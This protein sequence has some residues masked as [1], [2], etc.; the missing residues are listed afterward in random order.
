VNHLDKRRNVF[1]FIALQVP[2]MMP[3]DV[4]GQCFVFGGQ[5]LDPVF[6][7]YWK[8]SWGKVKYQSGYF[9]R[10]EES[11]C[12]NIVIK[13]DGPGDSSPDTEQHRQFQNLSA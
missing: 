5:F 6:P 13:P 12:N 4:F 11:P 8:Y 7:K 3:L 1:H 10:R 9:L 2:D